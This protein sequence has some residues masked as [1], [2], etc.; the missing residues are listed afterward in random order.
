MQANILNINNLKIRFM[1]RKHHINL[2][3]LVILLLTGNQLLAQSSAN[4]TFSTGT[5]GN[6]ATDRNGNAITPAG[7][8]VATS[9]DDGSSVVTAI[10]FDFYYLGKMYNYFSVSSNGLLQLHTSSGATAVNS[11]LYPTSSTFPAAIPLIAPY[12]AD[13]ITRATA[14]QSVV[15]GSSPNRC[16]T[17]QWKDMGLDYGSTSNN[18]TFQLR[19]YETKGIIEFVYGAMAV[20]A[21]AYNQNAI[22][23]FCDNTTANHQASCTQAAPPVSSTSSSTYLTNTTTG[24]IAGLNSTVATSRRTIT[25]IPPGSTGNSVATTL[26]N[27]TS[28][29]FSAVTNST[30]TVSWTVPGTTTGILGYAL[31]RS[32]D[33]GTT[34]TYVNSYSGASTATAGAQTGLTAGTNYTWKVVAYSE[35]GLSTGLTGSQYTSPLSVS[36][37]GP[38]AFGT[39]LINVGST[40]QSFTLSGTN[41]TG[42]SSNITVTAPTGFQVSKT[43]A[44]TGFASS[45]TVPYTSATLGATTIWV[46]VFSASANTY[47]GNI[48]FS[49]SY[50]GNS[51]TAPVVSVSGT[52]MNGCSGT[53]A[54]GTIV[55]S[56]A[57]CNSGTTTLS[58]S[59]AS[60]QPDLTY[61]WSSSTSSNGTFTNITGATSSTYTTP[62]LTTSSTVTYFKCAV[63]C[64]TSGI[65]TTTASAYHVVVNATPATPAPTSNTPVCTGSNV[66]LS[67]NTTADS[68]AW[69][70][71]NGFTSTG[72]NPT[73]TSAS[74]TAAGTYSLAV[75]T[76]GCPSATGTTTVAISY[77]AV[78]L[79]VT[80]S[81]TNLCNGS[82]TSLVASQTTT[83]TTSSGTISLTVPDNTPAGVNSVLAVSNVPTGATVTGIEVTINTTM[84]YDGDLIYNLKAPNGN[85]INLI[86]QQGTSGDNFTGTVVSSAGTT[87]FSAGTAPFTGTFAA[88]LG[89]AVGPTSFLSNVTAWTNILT[90]SNG[91]WTLAIN[92]NA[93]ADIA[94]INDWSIKLTYTAPSV[95]WS[96]TTSLYTNAGLTTAYTGTAAT[97]VYAAPTSTITYTAAATSGAC[98]ST[99][100]SAITV[101]KT[102][103]TATPTNPTTCGGTNGS[104]VLSGLTTGITYTVNYSKNGTTQTPLS[105]TAASGAVTMSSLGAGSYTNITVTASG[106]TTAAPASAT[107]SNPAAPVIS[108]S[109]SVS[110]TTCSGAN[111]YITLNGLT[112]STTY[113]VNYSKNG[114]AQTPVSIASNGSGVLNITGLNAATYSAV[115]VTSPTTLCTSSSVGSFVLSNPTAPS[116]SSSSSSN[117]TTCSGANG[118]ITFNGLSASTTYTINYSKNGVVQTPGSFTSNGS[119]VL[120]MTGLTSGTYSAITITSSVTNCTSAS[121]G[122]FTLSDPV[123][124]V[125]S[126]SSSSNPTICS[127]TNGTITLNGLTAST[128]YTVNYTKNGTAQSPASFTSNGS[129]SLIMTGLGSGT[130]ASVNVTSSVTSCTSSSVG[131]FTLSD[132]A[133]ISISS[134]SS[135]NPTTCSGSNG[136]ITLNGLAATTTY[137]VHYSKNG[138]AQFPLSITTNGSGVLVMNSLTAGT[139]TSVS[140]TS[141]GSSCTAT[142]ASTYTLSDPAT[143]VI[144]AS[145][146]GPVC[147]STALSLT[148]TTVSGATYSWTGPNSYSVQ[149]PSVSSATYSDAGTYSV[150]AT[151]NNCISNVATTTVVVN[152]N[153]WTGTVDA[154]WNNA[155]NWCGGV[156]TASMP[157]SIPSG[158]PHNPSMPSGVSIANTDI[159]IAN[160]V[161]I[162]IPSGSTLSI[163]GDA[164]INGSVTG[165][166]KI[167]FNGTGSQNIS[168]SA[169]VANLEL[170]NSAGATIAS[171]N[172]LNVTGMLTLT[173]GQLTTN[174][175]LVLASDATGTGC[176]GTITGGSISGLVTQ[177]R[178]IPGGRRCFR[179]FSH[180][181]NSDV[182]LNPE[183]TSQIDVTGPGGAANG[184]TATQTNNPSAFWYNPLIGNIS[185]GGNGNDPGWTYFAS[186]TAAT[187]ANAWKRYQGIRVNVRGAK[188]EGLS[189]QTYTPST[190]TLS[191]IGQVNTGAQSVPF[192]KGT[193]SGYNIIGNPYPCPVDIG[194]IIYN[195]YLAGDIHGSSFWVWD[196]NPGTIGAYVPVLINSSTHYYLPTAGA[197]VIDVNGN[198]NLTFNETDKVPTGTGLFKT[199]NSVANMLEMQLYSNNDSTY[200][201]KMYEVFSDQATPATEQLDGAKSGNPSLDFYALSSDGKKLSVDARPFVNN[202]NI[203]IGFK[204]ELKQNFKFKVM[205][206]TLPANYHLYLIDNYLNTVTTITPGTEYSFSTTNDSLSVG[207][208]RFILNGALQTPATTSVANTNNNVSIKV[209]VTPNPATDYTNITFDG[210]KAGTE[211]VVSITNING[212]EVYSM[213]VADASVA[214]INVPLSNLASGIYMVKVSCGSAVVTERLVK[215]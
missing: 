194:P 74:S 208:G 71:P 129:G 140:V 186:A 84:T 151:V 83:N 23:G 188:G 116:V 139:Y 150:T 97:T 34:Y 172:T 179:F 138:V 198:G 104:I 161:T 98:T 70:G 202:M 61:Q 162:D 76:N 153:T 43:S 199:T 182:P 49:G 169:T 131:S 157:V 103:I 46:R 93:S 118:S 55:S 212:Q 190:A 26:N 78:G 187:G 28:M 141:S 8:L 125:I 170:N 132:P 5:S 201:D 44:T 9:T 214:K 10:G 163:K 105:L 126:S 185:P 210:V 94:V 64:P 16:L 171:G 207:E 80:P 107:L 134:S 135:S 15:T 193:N 112:A 37:S 82:S 63:R 152:A 4:Y 52:T 111:G 92:D 109:S 100:T 35:G 7:T 164:V 53:P 154:N 127:G 3:I 62:T 17:V 213:H 89:S 130:Y 184:F 203:P 22:I 149:N 79:S 173:S 121:V 114:T 18:A 183:L 177:K 181:Y 65:T 30:T 101:I 180:P 88:S 69:S 68:Y 106:C 38:L 191:M 6:L 120:V 75:T 81:S 158:T 54:A 133:S 90:A 73:I 211:A 19:L 117:P 124:P 115:T 57:I 110:P 200:W 148:A 167:V 29:T 24:N 205:N 176:I 91:N 13:M 204:T 31:Y 48:T 60:L 155:A 144:T 50:A 156:P 95:T 108:S 137:T 215:K 206:Y 99:A 27:P 166:G 159:N 1:K 146:N 11:V 178:Y 113:T 39:V 87:A 51:S 33:G 14:V 42:F 20:G 86:N 174:S 41:L 209:S 122:P 85:I 36:T 96:P 72:Q 189:G 195:A 128:S 196:A 12:W 66:T 67:A 58:L 168:G 160:S 136:Y 40:A 45:V 197:F 47:T 123:V 2:L 77:P 147:Y 192:V 102:A 56:T 21:N 145:N 119:G 25:Y 143:P 175:G 165:N 142:S 32:T 59:G